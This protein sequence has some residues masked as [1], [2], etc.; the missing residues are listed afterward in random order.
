MSGGRAAPIVVAVAVAASACPAAGR[1]ALRRLH[2]TGACLSVE[3][4]SAC[5]P[6]RGFTNPLDAGDVAMSGDGRSLYLAGENTNA[7]GVVR[8]D[9]QNGR[10]RQEAGPQ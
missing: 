4:P 1:P 9:P 10:V 5:D 6:A 2:G 3:R 8:V 7:F